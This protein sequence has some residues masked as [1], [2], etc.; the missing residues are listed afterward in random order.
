MSLEGTQRVEKIIGLSQLD[1]YSAMKRFEAMTDQEQKVWLFFELRKVN[2]RARD[3]AAVAELL[4]PVV[5]S[6]VATAE[7]EAMIDKAVA[8]AATQWRKDAR[9]WGTI[10]GGVVVVGG[11]A[12]AGAIFKLLGVM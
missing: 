6:L 1:D 11:P 12:M 2:G 7:H 3:A 9:R 8:R 4:K 5:D 10:I